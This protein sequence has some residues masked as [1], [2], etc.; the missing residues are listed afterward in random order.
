VPSSEAALLML[1]VRATAA[2]IRRS[3]ASMPVA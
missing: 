3:A 2:K 1:P